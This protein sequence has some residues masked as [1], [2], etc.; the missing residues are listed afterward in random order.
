MRRNWNC[1]DTEQADALRISDTHCSGVSQLSFGKRHSAAQRALP[2]FGHPLLG[3]RKEFFE[4]FSGCLSIHAWLKSKN[5]AA[6]GENHLV[7]GAITVRKATRTRFLQRRT[8]RRGQRAEPAEFDPRFGGRRH[9]PKH[10]CRYYKEATL[11]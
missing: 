7:T 5:P 10:C 4:L 9:Y 11:S 3:H 1:F 8:M 6:D 2:L